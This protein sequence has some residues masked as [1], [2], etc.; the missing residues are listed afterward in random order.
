M[1]LIHDRLLEKP[2]YNGMIDGIKKIV[3]A[4]GLSGIYKGTLPTVI[5]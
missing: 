5:K 4:E 3:I 1:K 2:K